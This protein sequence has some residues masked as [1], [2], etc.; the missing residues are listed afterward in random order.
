MREMVEY[1]KK[2]R[3]ES[4]TAEVNPTGCRAY[5]NPL[6]TSLTLYQ[7]CTARC[8]SRVNKFQSKYIPSV[9]ISC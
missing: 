2:V 6:D 3:G 8:R 9:G 4:K 1:W 7:Y 5:E